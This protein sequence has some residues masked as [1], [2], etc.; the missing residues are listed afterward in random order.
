[1]TTK[2]VHLHA[3]YKRGARMLAGVSKATSLCG[4]YHL[5]RE[6]V[7]SFPDDADC[8]QCLNSHQRI[9]EEE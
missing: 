8:P 3:L 1:M 7:T 9:A 4:L 6:R 5:P 2:P